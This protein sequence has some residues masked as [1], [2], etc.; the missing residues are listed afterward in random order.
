MKKKISIS[1]RALEN[2]KTKDIA[3]IP[4]WY[5]TVKKVS[6]WS[7]ILV[8]VLLVA[9]GLS[10]FWFGIFDQ[11]VTPHTWLIVVLVFFV[12]S[13]YEFSRTKKGYRYERWQV[14]LVLIVI[15]L[16]GSVT[17]YKLGVAGKVDRKMGVDI[18]YYRRIVPMKLAT[19]N[20]PEVGYLS[21]IVVSNS[22]DLPFELED[23]S[24][25]QWVIVG[26]PIIRGRVK[27]D[28]GEEVKIVGKMLNKNE[29]EAEEIRPWS[30]M[31]R[32]N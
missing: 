28:S 2:I 17:M 24:G 14:V 26:E 3:P 23:F 16:L 19:W 11:I 6:I 13:I 12:L 20:R 15:G 10:I 21:G 18:P 25:K 30:G 22:S 1:K 32:N 8:G 31:G 29:F 9:L 4:A 7:V 5:F 27:L